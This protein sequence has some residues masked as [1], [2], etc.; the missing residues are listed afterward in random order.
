MI[1]YGLILAGGASSRFGFDKARA[2]APDGRHFLPRAIEVLAES[3]DRV[4]VLG[5]PREE[6]P[7]D[8]RSD[9]SYK[10]DARPGEG[11]LVALHQWCHETATELPSLQRVFV[12]AMDYPLMC[13]EFV[14]RLLTVVGDEVEACI[15]RALGFDHPLCAAY[16]GGGIRRL[17]AGIERS[18]RL[19]DATN[20]LTV[21][22]LALARRNASMVVNVN[23]PKVLEHLPDH[24][25]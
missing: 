23:R 14:A 21:V 18:R 7:R 20:N 9:V 16:S 24:C 19:N 1:T 25:V 22:R 10:E 5:S 8:T 2:I 6:L 3:T 15:P 4:V 17:V 11:P 13:P 12:M